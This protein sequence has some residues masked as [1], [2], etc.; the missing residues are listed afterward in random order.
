MRRIHITGASGSGTTHLGRVLA[1]RL[2]VPHFDTDDF[3]WLPKAPV[4]SV[5]RAP[6]ERLRLMHALFTPGPEWILS[7]SVVGWGD[8]LMPLFDLVIFLRT[9]TPIRLARLRER[10]E[11]RFGAQA[12]APGGER[13]AFHA[14]F[15]DWAAQ[16]DRADF[17][18]RSASRHQT[19]LERLSCPVLRLA[20]D[21]P[22]STRAEAVLEALRLW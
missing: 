7:G 10:E 16:Y 1:Q 12:L 2:D 15:L 6:E 22:I 14:S 5:K 3:Y 19:W 18:G 9:P 20:G 21:A 4:Y 13:H 17:E 11:R 8:P